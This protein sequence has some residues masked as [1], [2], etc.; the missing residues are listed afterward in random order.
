M[1]TATRAD[2]WSESIE[3]KR[4]GTIPQSSQSILFIYLIIF[5]DWNVVIG[6]RRGKKLYQKLYL[7]IL[8][9]TVRC[10]CLTMYIKENEMPQSNQQQILISRAMDTP[11]THGGCA[12]SGWKTINYWQMSANW[13]Q[14]RHRRR[15]HNHNQK[16]TIYKMYLI[17][18]SWLLDQL[19]TWSW[20]ELRPISVVAMN[21]E[22][23]DPLT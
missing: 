1:E 22:T 20:A 23:V 16:K 15:Q 14:I 21:G 6:K 11:P 8:W 17:E 2:P 10:L 3:Q 5:I 12:R 19:S 18:V 9:K 7:N 4:C 13:Q